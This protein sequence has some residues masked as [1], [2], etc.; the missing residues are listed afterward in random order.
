MDNPPLRSV[1]PILRQAMARRLYRRSKANGQITLPAVPSMVDE[2]VRMCETVFAAVGRP[3]TAEQLAHLKTLLRDQID[4]A[5][6]ATQRSDIVISFDAPEGTVL[7][8]YIEPQWVTI[9]G[10][11]ENWIATR[12]PPLF[13]TEPD[14]R[15]WALASVAPDPR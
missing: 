15:V 14:A 8:Y 4:R 11:Y 6:A 5:Y 1:D 9:E 13:G 2:Y 12:Q 7:N 10:A 3:F